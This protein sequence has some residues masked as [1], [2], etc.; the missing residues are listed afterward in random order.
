MVVNTE[1]RLPQFQ[2]AYGAVYAR[3]QAKQNKRYVIFAVFCAIWLACVGAWVS[4]IIATG[5]WEAEPSSI[6]GLAMF[7]TFII[8]TVG[9]LGGF[10]ACLNYNN[11]LYGEDI[12]TN[13][14]IYAQTHFKN[15]FENRY[16]TKI[17]EHQALSLMDGNSTT[18][19]RD[20]GTP[21]GQYVLVRFEY[22]ARNF[23]R[24]AE[25]GRYPNSGHYRPDELPVI[26]VD[27]IEFNLIITEQPAKPRQYLWT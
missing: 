13:R 11:E 5:S 9:L 15:W 21:G 22:T 3:N 27:D 16:G 25:F 4:S 10:D 1:V 6:P 17:T 24:F 2:P 8:P 12:Y 23:A 26:D 18:V 20:D 19:F 14:G 7:F